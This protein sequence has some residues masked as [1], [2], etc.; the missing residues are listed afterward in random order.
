MS[1]KIPE[2]SLSFDPTGNKS[3]NMAG[4]LGIK[5]PGLAGKMALPQ[6]VINNK[7]N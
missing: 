3:Q 7:K 2:G 6:T 1:L 5:I 4:L